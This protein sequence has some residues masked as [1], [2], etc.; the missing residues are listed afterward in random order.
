MVGGIK[1]K[2][3]FGAIINLKKINIMG[4]FVNNKLIGGNSLG[5]LN[6]EFSTLENENTDPPKSDPI[7]LEQAQTMME[8]YLGNRLDLENET[9]EPIKGFY[10][11]ADDIKKLVENLPPNNAWVFIAL[12]KKSNAS[13]QKKDYTLIASAVINDNDVFKFKHNSSTTPWFEFCKPCPDQ[14]PKW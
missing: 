5:D 6:K 2:G 10:F 13:S 11:D 14:C 4:G 9:D 3:S 8:N 12:A 1:L 7:G